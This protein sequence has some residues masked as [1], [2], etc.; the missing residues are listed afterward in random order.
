[1]LTRNILHRIIHKLEEIDHAY[2]GV[3]L[4]DGSKHLIVLFD[5]GKPIHSEVDEREADPAESV[6]AMI[7][8]VDECI[9][10]GR[11]VVIT[12]IDQGDIKGPE[13]AKGIYTCAYLDGQ[14]VQMDPEL[15]A[16]HDPHGPWD[17]LDKLL[18]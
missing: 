6:A 16:K 3:Q 13:S 15:L 2:L 1:M 8:L 4:R 11:H 9:E 18:D 5:Y 17:D 10:T 14:L 12:V 7:A